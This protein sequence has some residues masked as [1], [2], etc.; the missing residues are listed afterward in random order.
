MT[1]RYLVVSPLLAVVIVGCSTVFDAR[2]AQEAVAGKGSG[3]IGERSRVDLRG[4][5]LRELVDFALTNRPSVLSAR[6]AVE[7]ARLAM[8]QVAADAPLVSST[9]WTAPK[10]SL[11]AGYAANSE[12]SSSRLGWRT[13]GNASAALSLDLLI[14][15]FGR[16]SAEMSAAANE[17]IAAEAQLMKVGYEVFDDVTTAYFTVLESDALLEVARTNEFEYAEH[18]RQAQDRL[19]AGEAQRLDLTRARLDL[20]RAREKTVAAS[21]LVATSGAELMRALGIDADRGSREDVL[22]PSKELLTSVMRGFAS[23]TYTV[24]DAFGLARTN[25]PAMAI[26]RAR[27]R[28]ASDRVDFAVADL[29]PSVSASAS[30]NWSDPLW[31]WKW[32]ANGVQTLFQGFRKT[33]AVD[34]AVVALKSAAAAVDEAEQ[35]LSLRIELAIANRDNADVARNTAWA[36][37]KAARENFAT[38][39]EQYREGDVSRVDFTDAIGDCAEAVGNCISAF[40]RGQIAEARLFG[41]TGLVPEYNEEVI[42]EAK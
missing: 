37:V 12:S 38:V 28:A 32:G 29:L 9:P 26:A 5:S 10:L 8:K 18:L 25:A 20:S 31:F 4:S 36:S 27:L 21:N 13:E 17:V 35:E 42:R 23:T 6:L 19:A 16:N 14:W 7:D 2:E 11:G 33:T 40:Y 30:L 41:L 24:D 34:R 1:L 39:K 3:V 22:P 15:D